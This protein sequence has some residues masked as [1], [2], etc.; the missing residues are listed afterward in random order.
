MACILNLPH[1]ENNLD[2]FFE[3]FIETLHSTHA[4]IAFDTDA[5]QK[6]EFKAYLFTAIVPI[7]TMA[8]GLGYT[9][10][11]PD[12]TSG[13]TDAKCHKVIMSMIQKIEFIQSLNRDDDF[14]LLAL[15]HGF[16]NQKLQKIK[17]NFLTYH[18]MTDLYNKMVHDC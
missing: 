15:L 12:F 3:H 16:A 7:T 1:G 13:S 4:A 10:E 6:L 5:N 17:H 9:Q 2:D 18:H 14:R 8:T 11:D